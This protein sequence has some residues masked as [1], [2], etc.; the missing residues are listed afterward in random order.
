MTIEFD[1]SLNEVKKDTPAYHHMMA[2]K[3]H[4]D[5]SIDGYD[6]INGR[7]L[8]HHS[9]QY[10]KM[11]G[12]KVD[13]SKT[14]KKIRESIMNTLDEALMKDIKNT[15]IGTTIHPFDPPTHLFSSQDKPITHGRSLVVTKKHASKTE[16]TRA[17]GVKFYASHKTGQIKDAKNKDDSYGKGAF[18]TDNQMK[19]KIHQ[20]SIQKNESTVNLIEAIAEGDTLTFA[21]LFN[22]ALRTRIDEKVA[23]KKKEVASKISSDNSKAFDKIV[24]SKHK[25]VLTAAAK[26]PNIPHHHLNA[27]GNHDDP[28]VQHAALQNP[29]FGADPSK[30]EKDEKAHDKFQKELIT[31]IKSFKGKQ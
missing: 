17:D 28:H 5:M 29:K 22:E 24:K 14:D 3:A 15:P 23:A 31:H 26:H 6:E 2:N 27:L 18:H 9:F 4:A 25:Y 12:K 19:D 11:T 20:K 8:D 10:H 16:L 30:E 7:K 13:F 21:Q 1:E